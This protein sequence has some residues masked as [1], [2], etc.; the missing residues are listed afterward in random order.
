M[1]NNA[2]DMGYNFDINGSRA[3]C[4]V[5]LI[6]LERALICGDVYRSCIEI[7]EYYKYVISSCLFAY[8]I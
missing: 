8:F 2:C 5:N 1:E 3:Y 7:V 6:E 4:S